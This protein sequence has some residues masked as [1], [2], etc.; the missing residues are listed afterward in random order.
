[1]MLSTVGCVVPNT[2]AMSCVLKPSSFAFLIWMTCSLVNFLLG[3]GWPFANLVF[4]DP[5]GIFVLPLLCLSLTLS[6][7]VPSN[8]WAGLQQGGLSQRWQTRS[9]GSIPVAKKKA[10][11]WALYPSLLGTPS[12]GNLT[13]NMPYPSFPFMFPVHG[14]HSSGPRLS[15]RLRNISIRSWLMWPMGLGLRLGMS[16]SV[17]VDV[18]RVGLRPLISSR[19]V[20]LN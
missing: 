12:D 7:S 18:F 19:L 4:I 17:Q 14:Q 13:K 5:S 16:S 2:S 8:R 3:A 20:P 10:I 6:L 11:R 15:T 9:V 1:M